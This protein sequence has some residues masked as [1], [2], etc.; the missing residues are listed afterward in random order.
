M[1]THTKVSQVPI[2]PIGASQAPPADEGKVSPTR[3]WQSCKISADIATA[4]GIPVEGLRNGEGTH[5]VRIGVTEADVNV[6]F[7]PGYLE[8][9]GKSECF[10]VDG[11]ATGSQRVE[12]HPN[13]GPGTKDGG[14]FKLFGGG[15]PFTGGH[16][17]TNARVTLRR[18]ELTADRAEKLA[19][20]ENPDRHAME[21]ADCTGAGVRRSRKRSKTRWLLA[22]PLF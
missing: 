9:L 17:P 21:S 19:G 16:I 20:G 15:N 2:F 13:S 14:V 6:L 7:N 5:Q 8:F 4:L 12:I 1:P 22:L 3:R 18:E 11:I 10:V